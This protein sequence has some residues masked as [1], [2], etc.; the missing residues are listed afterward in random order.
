MALDKLVDSTQLDSDLASVADAIRAKSGGSSQL[1]FPA[2]FVSEIQAIPSGGGGA[3]YT[4]ISAVTILNDSSHGVNNKV[5]VPPHGTVKKFEV[6]YKDITDG[7]NDANDI[8][9]ALVGIGGISV[10]S[11]FVGYKSSNGITLSSKTEIDG[12]AHLAGSFNSVISQNIGVGSW[13]DGSYSKTN[14]FH[15]VKFFDASDNLTHHLIPVLDAHNDP[16]FFDL[17]NKDFYY[18][19][20]GRAMVAGEVV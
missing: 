9:I 19:V 8:V 13:S 17:I 10:T 4:E 16:C 3:V 12:Y 5:V 6:E 11:P 7:T 14:A 2:G 1:A 20:T 15:Y 18:L